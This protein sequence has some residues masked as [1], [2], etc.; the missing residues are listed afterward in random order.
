MPGTSGFAPIGIEPTPIGVITGCSGMDW[1]I[2]GPF[3]PTATASASKSI[4]I[5][6]FM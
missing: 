5:R 4:G 6:I 2:A 1:P 3:K